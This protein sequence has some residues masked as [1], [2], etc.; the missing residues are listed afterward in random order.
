ME[1]R[2]FRQGRFIPEID[3]HYYIDL[4]GLE[5]KIGKCI[6]ISEKG[7]DPENPF[8]HWTKHIFLIDGKPVS[9]P[10]LQIISECAEPKPGL[11]QGML[12]KFF[13]KF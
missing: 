6:A 1:Q 2:L 3:K 11:I 7:Q 5:T 8:L 9:I 13:A 10:E 4:Y 12:N